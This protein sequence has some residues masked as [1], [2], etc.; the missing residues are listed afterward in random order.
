VWGCYIIFSIII[1]CIYVVVY[2]YCFLLRVSMIHIMLVVLCI[3]AT[4]YFSTAR[5]S[6]FSSGVPGD[7]S[8]QHRR[9]DENGDINM[10]Y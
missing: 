5:S 10:S 7:H 1:F 9:A 8:V 3:F 2:S 6:I 4:G